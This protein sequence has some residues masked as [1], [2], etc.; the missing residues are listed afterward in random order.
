MR[1]QMLTGRHALML[2]LFNRRTVE[3]ISKLTVCL[4]VTRRS[5]LQ[6]GLDFPVR[7]LSYSAVTQPDSG[8]KTGAGQILPIADL[9]HVEY[10]ELLSNVVRQ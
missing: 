9:T 8:V 1:Y 10:V 3:L 5:L 7:A 6:I 4:C 2:A